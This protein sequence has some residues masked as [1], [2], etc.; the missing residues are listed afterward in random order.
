M[1]TPSPPPPHPTQVNSPQPNPAP[2]NP[3]RPNP[4][5]LCP[6]IPFPEY[7]YVPGLWPHPQ[8]EQ[9]NA[10]V[11]PLS[12]TISLDWRSCRA[13]LRG[14]DLFN[15]GYYWEAHEA[16]EGLWH[17]ARRKGTS[18]DFFKA[19][20]QLAVVGV[21]LRQDRMD[22]AQTHARRALELL[23]LVRRNVE[24]PSFFGLDLE[25]L[26]LFAEEAGEALAPQML[27]LPARVQIVFNRSLTP[28]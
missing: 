23:T 4:P 15:H 24:K 1:S 13:Y 16:W 9:G 18:A 28:R 12:E 7:S 27:A 6:E 11:E 19:L 2:S 26:A 17:A 5:R 8:A 20:I 10:A 25:E 3:V 22:G 14:L 21:K